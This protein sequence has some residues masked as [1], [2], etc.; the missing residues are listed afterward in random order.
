MYSNSI[1][2]TMPKHQAWFSCI[3]LL[4]PYP[5]GAVMN[6]AIALGWSGCLGVPSGLSTDLFRPD[7]DRRA[8][9]VA[10]RYD[11]G[12]P[13]SPADHARLRPAGGRGQLGAFHDENTPGG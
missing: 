2:G 5:G 4:C 7:A 8:G 6:T 1:L 11:A 3:T 9:G 13:F 10:R 12:D